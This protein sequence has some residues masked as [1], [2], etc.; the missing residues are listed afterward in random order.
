MSEVHSGANLITGDFSVGVSGLLIRGGQLA[1]P[2]QEATV[3]AHLLDILK[4]IDAV[5]SDL[6]FTTGSISRFQPPHRQLKKAVAGAQLWPPRHPFV[7]RRRALACWCM[8]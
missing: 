7:G 5:G 8:G 6:R 2:V 4:G 1:E 3:A